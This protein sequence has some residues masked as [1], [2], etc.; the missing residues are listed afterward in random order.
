MGAGAS[1]ADEDSDF[2]DA[3]ALFGGRGGGQLLLQGDEA[4]TAEPTA[5]GGLVMM[6]SGRD[7]FPPDQYTQHVRDL[8]GGHIRIIHRSVHRVG[9]RSGMPAH[10]WE[11]QTDENA[12]EYMTTNHPSLSVSRGPRFL[13]TA[14]SGGD[15]HPHSAL[16]SSSSS[17]TPSYSSAMG[18]RRTSAG[19]TAILPRYACHRCHRTFILREVGM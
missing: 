14:A 13:S 19:G 3:D 10:E 5:F 9:D 18:S 6:R 15:A 2:D 7:G 1:F 4:A 8:G 12:L 17:T 16:A 11:R